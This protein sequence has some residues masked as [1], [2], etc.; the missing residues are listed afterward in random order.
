MLSYFISCK[1]RLLWN[2][3]SVLVCYFNNGNDTFITLKMW[4]KV[5]VF[6]LSFLR[7]YLSKQ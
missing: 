6:Q 5:F 3:S 7:I 2:Y 4:I 1:V